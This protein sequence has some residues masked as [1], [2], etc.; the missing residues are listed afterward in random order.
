MLAKYPQAE[1]HITALIDEGH[2]VLYGVNAAK[3]TAR[4]LGEKKGTAH[5]GWDR[6]VFNFPHVG[7]KSTDI[8]RQVRYNQ[9]KAIIFNA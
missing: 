2:T 8:N 1:G 4:G 9:G 3:M 5:T 7:G 6:I